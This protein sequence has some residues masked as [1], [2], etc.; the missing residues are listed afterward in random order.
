MAD[1]NFRK[2]VGKKITQLRTAKGWSIEKLAAESNVPA[3]LLLKMEEG[4]VSFY[5]DTLEAVTTALG[6]D[7]VVFLKE[8][9]KPQT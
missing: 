7:G 9:V 8:A 3:D 2:D 6:I 5:I 1:L 4:T